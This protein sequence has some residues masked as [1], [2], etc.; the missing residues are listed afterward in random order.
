MLARSKKLFQISHLNIIIK[1]IFELKIL[2]EKP[3]LKILCIP[4]LI[5]KALKYLGKNDK[6][7][8]IIEGPSWIGYSFLSL[9]LDQNI[10]SIY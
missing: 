2:K 10:F 7:L 8:I 1:I 5:Y 4:Y 9:I 6:R 3:I